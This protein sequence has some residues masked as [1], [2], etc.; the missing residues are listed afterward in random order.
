MAS[1]I[2][3]EDYRMQK[4]LR[5]RDKYPPA[6][7]PRVKD[8]DI[9]AKNY[10]N[11]NDVVHGIVKI[12]Q[13]LD[14]HL[15]YSEDWKYYLLCLLDYSFSAWSG[16]GTGP[17]IETIDILKSYV[18]AEMHANNRKD[19]GIALLLLDLIANGAKKKENAS[20]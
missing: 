20:S 2:A 9:W 14:Y 5:N 1:V 11:Y 15:H 6:R 4:E 10:A 3:L 13:I 12:R 19:M 16:Q 17:M 18:A 8:A 7:Q